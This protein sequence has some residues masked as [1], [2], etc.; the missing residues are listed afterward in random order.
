[1]P[2]PGHE[3]AEEMAGGPPPR[4]HDHAHAHDVGAEHDVGHHRGHHRG[5]HHGH[6]H[7]G[8]DHAPAITAS[9][10]RRVRLVLALTASYAL[11]EAAAGWLSGS[12]ALIA[13]AGHMASDAAALLLALVAYRVAARPADASRTYGFQRV[14][15]L[16]ALANGAALIIL[17]A[18]I[19]WEA[20]QRLWQP[21]PV[22]AGP[23]LA[24]AV[25]GLL[26]NLAGAWL[27]AGGD[28]R[29]GNLRGAYL[30]VLG[31]LLGS[32][33]AIAAAI[34]ILLTGWTPLD[35]ILS[36]LVAA[37]V[38]RSAWG[39][40]RDN[41]GVLLQAAPEGL[42]VRAA[43]V[44]LATLPGVARAGHLHAWTLADQSAV[45]T[46]HVVPAAGADPLALPTLV[47][48]RLRESH[49]IAHATVQVDP[50]GDELPRCGEEPAR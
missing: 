10:A 49:G 21:S 11:V 23:M 38:L 48:A 43:E 44:D 39:L 30:H 40:V 5:H 31:D 29:D 9:N 12:L 24:V 36:V 33:G 42:D 8:H 41:V 22:L 34:G 7:A 6:G 1:M 50:P 4:P 20:A 37:L 18:W 45:A 19:A 16:A 3:H 14:R 2:M 47:A 13:D 32:V 35:P 15:V 46:V 17:V 25:L 26:V 28:R 27:L